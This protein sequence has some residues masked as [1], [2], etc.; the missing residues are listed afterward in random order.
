MVVGRPKERYGFVECGA[1]RGAGI[2]H[3]EFRAFDCKNPPPNLEHS[4]TNTITFGFTNT[5]RDTT[6]RCLRTMGE[7]RCNCHTTKDNYELV[8]DDGAK[9]ERVTNVNV[10]N[11]M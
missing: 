7:S 8:N 9:R 11:N 3:A 1:L 4:G 6:M 10:C 2:L 5:H